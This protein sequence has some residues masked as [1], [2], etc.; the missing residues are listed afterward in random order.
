MPGLDQNVETHPNGAIGA[1]EKLLKLPVQQT[2][3]KIPE[4]NNEEEEEEDAT[5]P[6]ADVVV[7]L[8]GEKWT[9]LNNFRII[10]VRAYK[11]IDEKRIFSYCAKKINR[12]RNTYKFGD[13]EKIVKLWRKKIL[14]YYNSREN[15]D[16]NFLRFF[17]VFAKVIK[18]KNFLSPRKSR[19]LA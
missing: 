12:D 11:Y 8:D 13:L 15:V 16:F 5:P 1:T 2:N 3:G 6:T 4:K 19:Q 10:I 9:L 18:D 7:P 17:A 14:I